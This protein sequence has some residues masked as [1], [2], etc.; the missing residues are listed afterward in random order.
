M[1]EIFFFFLN[2]KIG[3]FFLWEEGRE[4]PGSGRDRLISMED[5]CESGI[6]KMTSA[7]CRNRRADKLVLARDS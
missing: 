4:D 7:S 6:G 1:E 2:V 3:K 5:N